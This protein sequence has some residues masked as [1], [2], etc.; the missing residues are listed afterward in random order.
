MFA[1][2]QRAR[3]LVFLAVVFF[4]AVVV[5]WYVFWY[6]FGRHKDARN[7]HILPITVTPPEQAGELTEKFFLTI[8]GRDVLKPKLSTQDTVVVDG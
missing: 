8:A 4:A 3:L 6:L 2:G 1:L 5:E 7:V